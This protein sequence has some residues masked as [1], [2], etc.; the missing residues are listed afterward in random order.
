[1]SDLLE[2]IHAVLVATPLRWSQLTETVPEA[3]LQ[4][5]PTPSAWSVVEC[6][7]HLIITEQLFPVR[8]EALRH[9]QDIPAVDPT[10]FA[11]VSAAVPSARALTEQFVAM[12]EAS[13]WQVRQIT[14]DMLDRSG[15]HSEF[16]MVTVGQLLHEWAAH[17]LDHTMQ[18][19]RVLMQPFIQG[20]GPWQRFFAP[21]LLVEPTS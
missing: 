6:L 13:L 7:Q 4:Q 9:G 17:D 11:A 21:H 8:L 15:R 10:A 3:M 20:C 1:M 2:G 5:R 16:G 14:D 19:E 12:R 18:A